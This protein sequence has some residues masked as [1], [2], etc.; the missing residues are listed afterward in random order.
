MGKLMELTEGTVGM[1]VHAV[2]ADDE[3]AVAQ[4]DPTA[5][6][7]LGMLTPTAYELTQQAA[8]PVA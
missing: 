7:A 6:A 5:R 1:D 3:H 2:L 4:A 8:E